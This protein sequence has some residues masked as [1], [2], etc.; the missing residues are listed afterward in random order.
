MIVILILIFILFSAIFALFVFISF[1]LGIKMD[2][3]FIETHGIIQGVTVK[4]VD[5]PTVE[6]IEKY[7]IDFEAHNLFNTGIWTKTPVANTSD[8]VEVFTKDGF[9]PSN[10]RK[11][12]NTKIIIQATLPPQ[13]KVQTGD[14]IPLGHR[15]PAGE[16]S[17]IK[18]YK[19]KVLEVNE[20]D[21]LL[22]SEDSIYLACFDKRNNDFES[23]DIKKAIQNAPVELRIKTYFP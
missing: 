22:V 6:L 21:V 7:N 17:G 14:V 18:V 19:F 1:K 23:S 15:R 12:H 4:N 16:H 2:K 8:Q 3:K 11:L 20:N 13:C 5:L 9:A 10:I